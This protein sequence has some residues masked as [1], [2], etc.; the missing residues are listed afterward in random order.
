MRS[1]L[2][3]TCFANLHK[4][5]FETSP[6]LPDGELCLL[7]LRDQRSSNNR[8]TIQRKLIGQNENDLRPFMT[9]WAK[10]AR[11]IPF[12]SLLTT[13][14][15]S[16][17]LQCSF[18]PSRISL[19]NYDNINRDHS[20]RLFMHNIQQESKQETK[21]WAISNSMCA[22]TVNGKMVQINSDNLLFLVFAQH[23]TRQLQI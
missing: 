4:T 14:T 10:V 20:W 8:P 6:W 1:F 5:Y 22:V 11:E 19:H 2:W 18:G 23:S 21:I 17:V 3:Y 16:R 13:D 15:P 7:G 12:P 9:P